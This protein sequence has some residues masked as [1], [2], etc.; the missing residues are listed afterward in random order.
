LHD[1]LIWL[2]GGLSL[3]IEAELDPWVFLIV[4]AQIPIVLIVIDVVEEGDPLAELGIPILH[5]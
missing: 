1:N 3:N 5:K 2:S 4:L